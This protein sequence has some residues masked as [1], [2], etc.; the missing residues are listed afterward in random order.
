MDPISH[1]DANMKGLITDLQILIRQPS[2]SAQNQGIEKCAK[3]VQ[4]LLQKSGIKS[5]MLRLKKGVA[6]LV[7]GE[8]KSQ[9][10]PTKTL[11][12]YN[13]Y[14]VQP[15]EPIDLWN[16]PPFSGIQRGNKIFGRGATDDKGELITRIKAVEA[17]LKTTGDV[18]CNVKFLIEGEEETGS[19]H[20]QEYL[21]KYKQ[22]FSMMELSGNLDMLMQ[23]IDLL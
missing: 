6:P 14:D 16:D 1:I 7:Y 17:S 13:H 3:L 2:V 8:I 20:I 18:P 19:K 22:K 10:N 21:R 9:Q 11:M 5:E 15:V 23:K 4:K 12:F